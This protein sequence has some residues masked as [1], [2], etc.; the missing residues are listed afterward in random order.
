MFTIPKFEDLIA[1]FTL[2]FRNRKLEAFYEKTLD[3]TYLR[4]FSLFYLILISL[5]IILGT[6]SYF[7][8]Y[9]FKEDQLLAGWGS[10]IGNVLIFLAI[11]AELIVNFCPKLRLLRSGPLLILVFFACAAANSTIEKRPTARPGYSFPR[12]TI[13]L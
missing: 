10:G 11:V 8:Y 7:T 2:K 9:D 3:Q 12:L 13:P 6:T 1:P 4:S 5:T